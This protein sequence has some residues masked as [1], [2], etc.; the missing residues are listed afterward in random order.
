MIDRPFLEMHPSLAKKKKKNL[1]HEIKVLFLWQ[2]CYILSIVFPCQNKNLRI[3]MFADSSLVI[4]KG[5]IVLSDGISK[6]LIYVKEC[7]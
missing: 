1:W 7:I 6:H 3:F 2:E 5:K 4:I